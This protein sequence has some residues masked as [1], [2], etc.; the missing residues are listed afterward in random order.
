MWTYIELEIT[1]TFQVGINLVQHILT[2]MLFAGV[3]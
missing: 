3:V 1:S 2:Q